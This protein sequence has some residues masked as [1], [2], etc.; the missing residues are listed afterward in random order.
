MT[1]A[2]SSQRARDPDA[3]EQ[4]TYWITDPEQ[5][6]ALISP[7]RQ[8]I[9]D[10]LAAS[11]PMSIK[12]L[13]YQIGAQPSALYHH[14]ALMERV[15]L[16]VVSGH[17]VVNRKREAL[18]ATPAPRMRLMRALA[19][20]A[21]REIFKDIA[22]ALTRQMDRDF[23]RGLSSERQQVL[24]PQRNL[25]FF[26]LVSAPSAETLEKINALLGEIAELMWESDA[27]A[28]GAGDHLVLAWTMCPIGPGR[29]NGGGG[30]AAA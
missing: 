4:D 2:S 13:A 6:A 17:R 18:Y 27:K 20:P 23:E 1:R 30:D 5:I 19:D 26:R 12:E 11:G 24:G 8:E 3:T 10:H 14:I 16:V 29:A 21:H 22:G 9:G 25:G 7:R 28:E 15:G